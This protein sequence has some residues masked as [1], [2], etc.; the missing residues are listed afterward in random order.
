MG[1]GTSIVLLAVGAILAFAVSGVDIA[2]GIHLGVV[3]WILMAA[4]LL[5]LAV[6][7]VAAGPRRREPVTEDSVRRRPVGRPADERC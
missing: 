3:G 5:G 4:G 6:A 1:I 7:L 2:S